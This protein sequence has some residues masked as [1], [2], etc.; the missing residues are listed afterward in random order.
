MVSGGIGDKSGI[1]AKPA[2][3]LIPR[4]LIFPE[5]SPNVE[6]TAVINDLLG[7][8]LPAGLLVVGDLSPTNTAHPPAN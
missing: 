8:G 1:A 7:M 3:R 4:R 5:V 2:G 6:R